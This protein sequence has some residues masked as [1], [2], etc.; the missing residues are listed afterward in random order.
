M[1]FHADSL[2]WSLSAG[3]PP[4]L[5]AATSCDRMWT[6][7]SSARDLL[8]NDWGSPVGAARLGSGRTSGHACMAAKLLILAMKGSGSHVPNCIRP[9]S[10]RCRLYC[11]GRLPISPG[12]CLRTLDMSVTLDFSR[13]ILSSRH[14]RSTQACFFTPAGSPGGRCTQ[15]SIGC[16][17]GLSRKRTGHGWGEGKHA[18]GRLLYVATA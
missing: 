10:S 12:T 6:V 5:L 7:L 9:E 15:T 11:G 8:W 3:Q 17:C 2:A 14:L 4:K 13:F 16:R 1:I 18:G